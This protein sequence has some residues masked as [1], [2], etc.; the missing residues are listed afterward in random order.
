MRNRITIGINH[1]CALKR[2]A[3]SARQQADGSSGIEEEG[4]LRA[5]VPLL[6]SLPIAG[7][8][9]LPRVMAQVVLGRVPKATA[10]AGGVYRSRSAAAARSR[11]SLSPGRESSARSHVFRRAAQKQSIGSEC[12]RTEAAGP[13]SLRTAR[14]ISDPL[15]L[16]GLTGENTAAEEKPFDE[17][18]RFQHDGCTDPPETAEC[19]KHAGGYQ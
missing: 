15:L 10:T 13:S 8:L 5:T 16:A 1:C 4:D 17:K 11:G 12:W 14:A 7:W 18:I 3:E 9:A 2:E 6:V 19:S